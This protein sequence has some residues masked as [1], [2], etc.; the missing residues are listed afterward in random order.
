M[1]KYITYSEKEL[2]ATIQYM[3]YHIK[4]IEWWTNLIQEQVDGKRSNMSMNDVQNI[5]K[6]LKVIKDGL[7]HFNI[8]TEYL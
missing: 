3:R 8:N 6:H 1:D 4:E 7:K 5:A 2:K